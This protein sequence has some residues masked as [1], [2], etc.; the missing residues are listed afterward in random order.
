M[1]TKHLYGKAKMITFLFKEFL[2][3]F[4]KSIL[5]GMS[6]NNQHLSILNGHANHVTLEAIK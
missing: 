2:S 6:L 5:G 4:N 1:Q 3:F